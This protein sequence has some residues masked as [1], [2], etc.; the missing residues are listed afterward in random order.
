MQSGD[1]LQHWD[2][3]CRRAEA[4]CWS[5]SATPPGKE[6]LGCPESVLRI[7]PKEENSMVH[8]SHLKS[9]SFPRP[10]DANA[11]LPAEASPT[12]SPMALMVGC[13]LHY[14]V[15][16]LRLERPSQHPLPTCG[17]AALTK[18][19]PR[20]SGIFIMKNTSLIAPWRLDQDCAKHTA[21]KMVSWLPLENGTENGSLK[22]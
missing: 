15:L 21:M 11:H 1:A 20:H 12:L 8:S 13:P 5:P 22:K 14:M 6:A 3:V 7:L 4:E 19:L 16:W 18:F 9:I 2:A 17:L 10:G